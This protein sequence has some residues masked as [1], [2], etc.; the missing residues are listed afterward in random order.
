MPDICD[1]TAVELTRRIRDKSLSPVE[2][3]DSCLAR[4]AR[5]N[6]AVNAVITL[7]ETAARKAAREAEAKVMRGEELP[8][9]H[10][11]P[12]ANK[13]TEDTA[14]L[15]TT[16]GSPMFRDH[17][18]TADVGPVARLRA[19]GAVIV[20]KTNTP[21]WA[22]GANSRNPVNGI[23]ANPF[24]LTKSAAGSS[25][26]SG[27][28]LATGMVPLASGSDTGGSLRNPAAFNG[29]VGLRP[30]YGLVPNEKRGQGWSSIST[31]GPMARD[32]ADT[33]LMLSVMA[34][35]D[36]RDP[37]AYTLPGEPVR[38]VPSRFFPC[39]PEALKGLRVAITE[40]FGFAPTERHIRRVFRSRAAAVAPLFAVAEEATPDCT[41]ADDSFAVL[42]AAMFLSM[43]EGNYKNRPEMLGP[44][45]RANV[46]EGLG[47]T[48][49]DYARAASTQTKIYRAWQQFFTK[50]DIIIA[51]AITLSPRPWAESYP[52]EIDGEPTRSYFHW[53]AMAYAPTLAGHPAISLSMG[54]DE[55]G[56]PFGFQ[57]IGPRG[58][59]AL[60]LRVAAAIEAAFAHDPALR[61]PRPDLDAL[62]AARPIAEVPGFYDWG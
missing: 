45:V 8:A 39:A 11:L 22:A 40:D 59:D 17:V 35:D 43:H 16:Y 34:S 19:A 42:R 51:P 49:S 18:P 61:R 57:I 47:Y 37:L 10:G 3:L 28:A 26:G 62:A 31:N 25:G 21:E 5:V 2:I 14:G 15:R 12:I 23:T 41:G 50:H 27:V 30:S 1:L 24:D 53:L 48:L 7:D 29:I 44:L 46:E 32:V 9:L 55:L 38:G 36:A 56:M 58:A 20:G 60:L 54:L 6:P 13:E 4:I 52:A 33:A